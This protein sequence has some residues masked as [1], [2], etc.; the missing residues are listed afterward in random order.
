[1]EIEVLDDAATVARRGAA[2]LAAAAR[3][4]AAERGRFLVALSGGSTPW[5]MLGA[6]ADEDVPWYA[7]HVFQ[8][9]ERVAPNGHPERNLTHLRECL[10]GRLPIPEEQLH[11]MPVEDADLEIAARDYAAMLAASGRPAEANPAQALPRAN[12]RSEASDRPPLPQPGQRGNLRWGRSDVS[13]LG[14][15]VE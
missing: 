7:V 3:T 11:A 4:A 1:M 6:L 9:D 8:V 12:S 2:L 10:L 13:L 5:Q 14:H 15:P